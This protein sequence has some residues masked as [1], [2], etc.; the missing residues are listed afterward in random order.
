M[1]PPLRRDQQTKSPLFFCSAFSS[2]PA[3]ASLSSEST[4]AVICYSSKKKKKKVFFPGF[5]AGPHPEAFFFFSW[6]PSLKNRKPR[7]V[8]TSAASRR[9]SSLFL[10]NSLVPEGPRSRSGPV[11][12][13]QACERRRQKWKTQFRRRR[14]N[15]DLFTLPRGSS[16]ASI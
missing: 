12:R 2:A 7:G 8:V 16:S 11:S 4:A 9:R 15:L 14:G 5:P 13:G 1:I 10:D 6:R 3:P